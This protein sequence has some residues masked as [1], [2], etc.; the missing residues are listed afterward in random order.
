LGKKEISI[1]NYKKMMRR[2][3]PVIVSWVV[4][5]LFKHL[6]CKES[7]NKKLYIEALLF[8]LV[9]SII[10][11]IYLQVFGYIEGMTTF[12][13]TCPNGHIMVDDPLNK[14]QQTCV[15]AG[16]QTYPTDMK[17]SSP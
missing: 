17:S 1:L 16:H 15:P 13:K 9:T 14:E 5:V 4:Y 11:H 10:M 3:G 2:L 7:L 6:Y 12:G 8:S